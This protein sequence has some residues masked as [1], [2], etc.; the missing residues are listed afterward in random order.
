[1]NAAIYRN[2][3]KTSLVAIFLL[4]VPTILS[5]SSC[6]T[7]NSSTIMVL[8]DMSGTWFNNRNEAINRQL[9]TKVGTGL[10]D[11][12]GQYPQPIDIR[13]LKIG[14]NSY[15][16]P[17]LCDV[18][19][20]PKL[21]SGSCSRGS[22]TLH[23]MSH[24]EC[25]LREYVVQDCLESVLHRRGEA[26]TDISGAF[27]AAAKFAQSQGYSKKS[28][29]VL[30]DMIEER[31]GKSIKIP[32]LKGFH[33]IILYRHLNRHTPDM[34]DENLIKW[35]SWLKDAGVKR[36]TILPG[37][38]SSADLLTTHLLQEMQE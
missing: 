7:E 11:A 30:S 17:P 25:G 18:R 21:F 9:L 24:P 2:R 6:K 8:V 37:L 13:Y 33:V 12:A 4:L 5:T 1:M 20:V 36:V 3:G 26:L 34:T 15:L 31:K 23:K 28:L 38:A 22:K 14:S 16:A 35:E 19:F 32:D 29:I 10:I 27:A